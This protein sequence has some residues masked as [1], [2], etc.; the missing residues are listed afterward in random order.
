[1]ALSDRIRE[2][3]KN[4]NLTQGQLGHLIGVAKTTI[5]GYEKNREPTAAKLGEIAD[6]LGVDANF[7]L[8]DE[9]KAYKY[10]HVAYLEPPIIKKYRALDEHGRKITDLVIE[11]ETARIQAERREEPEEEP[12]T[13]VIPLYL[14]PAAAGYASPALGSD[15]EEYSVPIESKADFACKIQGDSM[16][17]VIKD[18]DIV[19]VK[20]QIDLEPGDVGLFYVD[21][22]MKCKQYCE[23]CYGN[24]YL[25][26]LNR[27]RSDADVTVWASSG[28]SVFCFGKVM[29]DKRPP[30]PRV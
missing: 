30:L 20:R 7:L 16:E 15:Y 21:G 6:A 14:T 28:V 11:E 22:D 26:S 23:D 27:E 17:P 9:M 1:M 2:A 25:F 3:R 24:I 10:T 29:L 8:Q 4:K 18:G 13:K 12:K 19:L 5:A